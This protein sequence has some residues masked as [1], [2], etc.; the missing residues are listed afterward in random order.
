MALPYPI[1]QEPLT[2]A[3]AVHE[4]PATPEEAPATSGPSF[5]TMSP[6]ELIDHLAVLLQQPELPE[7][8]TV[9][10]IRGQ[11]IRR[12]EFID[13]KDKALNDAYEVQQLRLED[14]M[15]TFKEHDRK[16]L[17]AL[18]QLYQENKSKRE[19]LLSRMEQL[20]QENESGAEFGHLYTQYEEIRKEWEATATL[21]PKDAVSL[22]KRYYDLREQFYDLKA[23]NDDL[24]QL[25]FKRN[26]EGKQAILA[27]LRKLDEVEDAV[28]A[29][30]RL[31]ELTS[32]WHE[33]GPVTKEL[34]AEINSEF[35]QLSSVLHKRHQEYHDQRKATEEEN[36]A[37]KQTLCERVEELL[38]STKLSSH[39]AFNKAVEEIKA[40]QAEWRTIGRAPRKDNDQ[41][42][43]R[44]RAGIDA[45]FRRR[46][47]F[48]KVSHEQLEAL[49]SAKRELISRAA[50]LKESTDWEPT[51]TA[52]KELQKEWQ[53]LG[54]LPPKYNQKLW[55][56][57]RASFDYFF[58][59]KK[60][61]APRRE[62]NTAFQEA[63]KSLAA[64]R[65]ILKALTAINEGETP[66]NLRDILADYND[67]WKKT[68][69]VPYRERENVNAA[70]R[71]L[72]DALH[73]KARRQGTERRVANYGASLAQRGGNLQTEHFRLQRQLERLRSEL[74][75]YDNN[76]SFL[77]ISSKSGSSLLTEIEHKREKLREDIRLAEQKLAVLQEKEKSSEEA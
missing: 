40:M 20:F 66:D 15:R 68:G 17:E 46:N 26:L 57:F 51:A 50:A 67:R 14:L 1:E 38:G 47:E 35:K 63:R 61:E 44:F 10:A 8:R 19:A 41:I 59:R 73:A 77:S 70:Y 12:R 2:T 25:D 49:L 6:Q 7:R 31:Q 74:Q 36:L 56:E 28:A 21:D 22:N 64:K 71:E 18:E 33:L 37:A 53:A 75:T 62:K 55:E 48:F 30:H 4:G 5:Q 72:L 39:S 13:P 42:Y 34:R 52:L 69:P 54:V 24:R 76:L 3:E 43:Q 58:E 16:R 60:K 32:Q 27:E 9:E 23:I 29:H 65:E 45:F 11:F